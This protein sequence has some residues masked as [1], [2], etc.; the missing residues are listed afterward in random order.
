MALGRINLVDAIAQKSEAIARQKTVTLR[1]GLVQIPPALANGL[2]NV[3][4]G[5]GAIPCAYL[6]NY[7]PVNNDKVVVINERDIWVVVG[8]LVA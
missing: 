1:I 8:K 3:V 5:G 6:T 7:T 4:V 2:V